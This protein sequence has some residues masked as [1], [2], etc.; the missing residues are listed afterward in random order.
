MDKDLILLLNEIADEEFEEEEIEEMEDRLSEEQQK[1]LQSA[2]QT[3]FDNSDEVPNAVNKA[4]AVLTKIIIAI[5]AET[6]EEKEE[7][8]SEGK[9]VKKASWGFTLVPHNED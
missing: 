3:F 4:A 1:E 9:K 5:T 7:E 2:L 8:D 6:K